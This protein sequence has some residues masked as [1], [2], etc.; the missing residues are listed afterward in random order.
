MNLDEILDILLV[1]HENS[2]VVELF[3][4]CIKCK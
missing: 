1:N 2:H 4:N 3:F